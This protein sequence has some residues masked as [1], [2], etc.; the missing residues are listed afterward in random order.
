MGFGPAV[1]VCRD[2]HDGRT[3]DHGLSKP[4][5]TGSDDSDVCLRASDRRERGTDQAFYQPQSRRSFEGNEKPGNDDSRLEVTTGRTKRFEKS[6]VEVTTQYGEES[7]PQN[8][9]KTRKKV[10][11]S[12]AT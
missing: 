2:L 7:K 3:D 10:E 6:F 1:G 9:L 12:R 5:A 4:D 11:A 8:T